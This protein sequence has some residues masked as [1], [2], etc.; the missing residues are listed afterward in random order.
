MPFFAATNFT[1][2]ILICWFWKDFPVIKL[3]PL[4]PLSKHSK[5]YLAILI[6]LVPKSRRTLI[7]K[8]PWTTV[9]LNSSSMKC[10]S[11]GRIYQRKISFSKVDLGQLY[12]KK[13][14]IKNWS[15]K[16]LQKMIITPLY[17]H[18][19]KFVTIRKEKC[20]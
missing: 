8:S 15:R 2:T 3:S 6:F 1:V 16:T 10:N 19:F 20:E 13:K 14:K 9:F 18:I 7:D 5:K 12:K 4:M 17:T 11:L